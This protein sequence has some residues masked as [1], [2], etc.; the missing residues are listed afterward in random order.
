MHF[1]QSSLSVLI[2][3]SG[4]GPSK[5]LSARDSRTVAVSLDFSSCFLYNFINLTLAWDWAAF[6]GN[7]EFLC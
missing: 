2:K 3:D 1:T 4:N 7:L 5:L 6:P